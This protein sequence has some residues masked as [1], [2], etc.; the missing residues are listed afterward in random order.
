MPVIP[1]RANIFQ[2][3]QQLYQFLLAC[4][5]KTHSLG[6]SQIISF[7]QEIELLDP[8]AVYQALAQPNELNFYWEN[9]RYGEAIAAIASTKHITIQSAHRFTQSQ[10]FIRDCLGQTIKIGNLSIPGSGPRFFCS[11]TF[12]NSLQQRNSPF[13]SATVFLPRFQI[14]REKDCCVLV[15]NIAIDP[16]VNLKLLIEEIRNK[17]K[18]IKLSGQNIIQLSNEKPANIIKQTKIKHI[19]L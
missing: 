5:E 1:C 17:R 8:L 15:A 14:T 3:E 7:S 4:Q 12:F 6:C 2:D 16:Q 11:F 13:P 19:P 9:S 10:Q 18:L